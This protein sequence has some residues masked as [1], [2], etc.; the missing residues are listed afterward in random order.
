MN[1]ARDSKLKQAIDGFNRYMVECEYTRT[2]SE[3]ETATG[4]N[5]YM[6]ECEFHPR[7]LPVHLS[8]RF[9]RYMVECEYTRTGSESETATGFNRYMVEC[10]YYNVSCPHL[11]EWVLIDTWWNV[12]LTS[13]G[14]VRRDVRVL[15]DTWWNVN[16]INFIYVYVM[17]MGFNR[18][19]VECECIGTCNGCKL[20]CCFNRYMVEC[21]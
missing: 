16:L 2:G 17:R 9:N 13:T 12:N 1:I 21:E 4:F 3:S 15:I 6:V 20:F 19:M 5:R 10:E 18:Y 14:Y 7:G 8:C 11:C